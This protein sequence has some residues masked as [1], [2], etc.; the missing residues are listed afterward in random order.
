MLKTEL[1]KALGLE[2]PLISAGMAFVAGPALAAA[3]S[4]AG[5]L[6]MLGTGMAPPEGLRQMIRATRTLT[7]RPF[8]VDLIGQEYELELK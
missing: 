2:T 5:G 4:N 1:S 8:G 3:V 6:G 7:S